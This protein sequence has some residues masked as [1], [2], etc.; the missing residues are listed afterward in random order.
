MSYLKGAVGALLGY[1]A[2][3]QGSYYVLRYVEVKQKESKFKTYLQNLYDAVNIGDK[4]QVIGAAQQLSAL[5]T[6]LVTLYEMK[7]LHTMVE[8]EQEL[9]KHAA[10]Q[11]GSDEGVRG[12]IEQLTMQLSKSLKIKANSYDSSVPEQSHT[13]AKAELDAGKLQ[14]KSGTAVASRNGV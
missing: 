12:K 2:V 4:A 8:F 9:S 13:E 10:K 11:A 7:H 1:F 6:Q 14:K 5:T 3:Q